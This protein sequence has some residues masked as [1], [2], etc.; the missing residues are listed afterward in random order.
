M[1]GG[2]THASNY[3]FL[4]K[5]KISSFTIVL[6]IQISLESINYFLHF[7]ILKFQYDKNQFPNTYKLNFFI[8]LLL[9]LQIKYMIFLVNINIF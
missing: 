6:N 9:K 8:L 4:R 1:V 7:I 3:S 2:E 5:Y